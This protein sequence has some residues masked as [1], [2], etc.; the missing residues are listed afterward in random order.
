MKKILKWLGIIL[1]VL[2]AV[3]VLIAAG[4]YIYTE[5]MINRT[6]DIQ[7]EAVPIPT[8]EASLERG[9]HLVK[10][11]GA[12]V[13]CHGQD[14]AGDQ[15]NEGALV[16][17]IGVRNLTSGEG[18]IGRTFTDEDWVRAIRHGVGTDDKSLLIMPSSVYHTLSD[19][20]L[21][22]IIAYL[23]TIPPVDKEIAETT[24]G[25]LG[26]PFILQLPDVLV[27]SVIDH[28]APRDDQ[29][30]PAV[31]VEYGKYLSSLLCTSC[32]GQDLTGLDTEEGG[33]NIT[34]GSEVGAWSEGD[35]LNTLRTGVKP[36]GDTIDE[37]LMPLSSVSGMT[38]D[39]FRAIWL[40]LQSLPAVESTPT[41]GT[42]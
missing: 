30:E 39:E 16:A 37:E 2:L 11:V 23:K 12:C 26:R 10:N 15:W 31:S 32:H 36:D 5:Q 1:G 24:V 41:P 8:D 13:E 21:G 22:A 4:L 25:P 20:D 7:V 40:Y 29:I 28:D 27:A 17:T 3:V 42:Q 38:D 14:L 19:A 33:P 34:P 6:Y 18:G 35:F 9:E